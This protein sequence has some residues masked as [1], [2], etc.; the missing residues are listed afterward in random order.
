MKPEQAKLALIL[1]L[2]D[3]KLQGKSM[4]V[5]LQNRIIS[6]KQMLL[7]FHVLQEE[8]KLMQLHV[9]TQI[10]YIEP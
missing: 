9:E 2:C 10:F 3:M 7:Q 8:R 1:L 5:V 6:Y 4:Y